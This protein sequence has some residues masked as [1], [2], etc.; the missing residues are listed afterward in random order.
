M[1]IDKREARIKIRDRIK[2]KIAMERSVERYAQ[3]GKG[4]HR[5]FSTIVKE[6]LQELTNIGE[7]GSEV[8]HFI[9]EPRNFVEVTELSENI[10]KP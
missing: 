5:V 4:L 2:Q 9:S 3:N 6:I 1:N 7:S 10:R 8:S